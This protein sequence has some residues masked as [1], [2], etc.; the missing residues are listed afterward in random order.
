MTMLSS[1]VGRHQRLQLI[2]VRVDELLLVGCARL[3]WLILVYPVESRQVRS[4]TARAIAS[5]CSGSSGERTSPLLV[6]ADACCFAV[7]VM[8]DVV[9]GS[10]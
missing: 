8:R 10:T 3:L 7:L 4:A 9:T 2:A 5:S 1:V 6:A